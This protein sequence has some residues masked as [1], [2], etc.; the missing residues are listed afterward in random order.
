[1]Q[2]QFL[3]IVL[4]MGI[5]HLVFGQTQRYKLGDEN[6]RTWEK[7]KLTWNDFKGDPPPSG[8]MLYYGLDLHPQKY[9]CH[10][11]TF[12]RPV[13]YAII[14]P[15]KSYAA[16]SIQNAQYLQYNQL[17]FDLVE[18]NRRKFQIE[19]NNEFANP[20]NKSGWY[21]VDNSQMLLDNT[22]RSTNNQIETMSAETNRGK[23][24]VL[25]SQWLNFAQLQLEQKPAPNQTLIPKFSAKT[26][27]V[28]FSFSPMFM[29]TSG[30]ISAY[31]P[32]VVG[33]G[34]EAFFSY[35][36]HRISDIIGFAD[37]KL[38]K[39]LPNT[40]WAEGTTLRLQSAALMYGY[41][42]IDTKKWRIV[43]Q[44][45]YTGFNYT[46]QSDKEKTIQYDVSALGACIDAEYK[47]LKHLDM[48]ASGNYAG[49]YEVSILGRVQAPL[50]NTNTITGL[51][52]L[53][54]IGVT[55]RCYGLKK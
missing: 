18:L 40:D 17:V 16:P 20:A 45:G 34:M 8:Y 32:S 7:G 36:K 19:L 46:R 22:W 39:Q 1:M 9:K 27:G 44:I 49:F 26:F 29:A 31:I 43:P 55:G 25:Y 33:G 48:N 38:V 47:I 10:D 50:Y 52:I 35:K 3:F 4:F 12:V 30:N 24:S 11:T 54:S 5:S 42:L 15:Q 37:P 21:A 6:L 23:D 2:K 13:V 53:A 41:E 28:G 14:D 51:P